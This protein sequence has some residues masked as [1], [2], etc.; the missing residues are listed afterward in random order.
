MK[1]EFTILD[2]RKEALEAEKRIKEYI[3]ETPLEH[4]FFLSQLAK[5]S[6]WIS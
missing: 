4:D 2:V 5:R 3:R 1:N 6:A